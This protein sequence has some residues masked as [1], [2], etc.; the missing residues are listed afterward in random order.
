[1]PI[2]DIRFAQVPVGVTLQQGCCRT[3][4]ISSILLMQFGRWHLDKDPLDAEALGA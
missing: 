1:M 3:A 4:Y 2:P